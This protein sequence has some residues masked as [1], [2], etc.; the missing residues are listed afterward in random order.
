MAQTHVVYLRQV[1]V[2]SSGVVIDTGGKTVP[3]DPNPTEGD[4][5]KSTIRVADYSTEWRV[6]EN[7]NA[8]NSTN[9]PDLEAY[10]MLEA[11]DGF[12]LNHMGQ[13]LIITTKP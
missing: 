7:S 11:A 10:L 13:S 5:I 3:S 6:L 9:W 12:V 1:K 2:N 4:I 8:P